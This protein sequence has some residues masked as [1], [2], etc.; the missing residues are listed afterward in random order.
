MSVIVNRSDEIYRGRVF[1]MIRENITLGNGV[2]VNI[3]TIRHP[4]ASAI[5]PVQSSGNLILIR[6]YRHS[7]G[8]YI[9]EIPAGTLSP[10]EEPLECARRELIEETGFS[11]QTWQKLGEIVPVPGY[12]DERIHIFKAEDLHPAIQNPDEDEIL[13]VHEIP[14]QEVLRMAGEGEIQD[15]KSLSALFL[16]HRHMRQMF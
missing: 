1:H 15:S 12:S 5:V 11:A 13:D 3:D 14:L 10:G 2:T 9:W 8:G 6:Q 16:L 4:G 7:V